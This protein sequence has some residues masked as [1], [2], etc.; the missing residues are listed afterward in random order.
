MIQLGTDPFCH[1]V[2]FPIIAYFSMCKRG[3]SPIV[4]LKFAIVYSLGFLVAKL[5]DF[6]VLIVGV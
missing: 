4:S 1:V 2:I 6:V 5:F 3:L